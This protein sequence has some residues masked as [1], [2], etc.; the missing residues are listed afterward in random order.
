[1][2]NTTLLKRQKTASK[3]KSN[4]V[5]E[6]ARRVS[7]YPELPAFHG[8]CVT[9]TGTP[10]L[11]IEQSPSFDDLNAAALSVYN[12]GSLPTHLSHDLFVGDLDD[13]VF[14]SEGRVD[15]HEDDR[16]DS[17]GDTTAASEL[18][19]FDQALQHNYLRL[20]TVGNGSNCNS[21]WPG[22]SQRPSAED[23]AQLLVDESTASLSYSEHQPLLSTES[24]LQR[25][26]HIAQEMDILEMA[27]PPCGKI[28]M[29]LHGSEE[30]A[31]QI[32]PVDP[33][34]GE[35]EF[36]FPDEAFFF[37]SD[38]NDSPMMEIGEEKSFSLLQSPVESAAVRFRR[39]SLS[40]AATASE[41]SSKALATAMPTQAF[42]VSVVQNYMHSTSHAGNGQLLP[43]YQS[44]P[45]FQ[46]RQQQHDASSNY[47][48]Q[49]NPQ[50]N[51]PFTSSWSTVQSVQDTFVS[52]PGRF[53]STPF[54]VCPTILAGVAPDTVPVN[55]PMPG[56]YPAAALAE[57]STARSGQNQS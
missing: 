2:V 4:K 1:V 28:K 19:F 21:S 18:L 14:H 27:T 41:T 9:A 5:K 16:Q 52:P 30:K 53:G 46:Q 13:S 24:F 20:Q 15:D 49:G 29:T 22:M 39:E 3:R 47:Q 34:A 38:D 56:V 45:R 44:P 26:R 50:S 36:F 6:S 11:E 42:G 57:A 31:Y 23:F 12:S 43:F 7:V 35:E 33:S 8:A 37:F 48:C 40:M 55:P 17:V 32:S 51:L 54:S 10:A 25:E